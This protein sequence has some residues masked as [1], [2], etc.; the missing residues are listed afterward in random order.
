MSPEQLS[1]IFAYIDA[2]QTGF[3]IGGFFAQGIGYIQLGYAVYL[4]FRDRS[5]A[6]PF[7]VMLFYMANDLTFVLSY[8]KWFHQIGDPL[9][10]QAWY[11]MLPFPVFHAVIA[12]QIVNYSRGEVFPGLSKM[13]AYLAYFAAQLAVFAFFIWLQDAMNDTLQMQTGMMTVIGSNMSICLL[14]Q[15]RNRKG[16]SMVYAWIVAL[17]AG[18]I[19]WFVLFPSELESFTSPA[20]YA[21]ATAMS[22][23]SLLY[24]Y[25]L[26]KA[27]VYEVAVEPTLQPVSEL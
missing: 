21:L 15:R 2:H 27:P 9:V 1:A 5:H 16:Q 4:G 22:A 12:W 25:L 18:P 7:F 8:N 20:F 17:C 13:Q 11:S 19:T 14:A 6:I 26:S 23:L 3:L 10:V 24:P